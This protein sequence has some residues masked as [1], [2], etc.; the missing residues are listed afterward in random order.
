M[1]MAKLWVH[2]RQ[3]RVLGHPL[4][5]ADLPVGIPF[6]V[7][8]ADRLHQVAVVVR[9][10]GIRESARTHPTSANASSIRPCKSLC[11]AS[12]SSQSI[13]GLPGCS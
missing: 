2:Q 3:H 12:G 9:L 7:L 8:G 1:A 5:Q 4:R 13:F 10:P 6:D 11:L